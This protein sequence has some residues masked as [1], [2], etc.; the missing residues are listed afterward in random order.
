MNRPFFINKDSLK[1]FRL[2]PDLLLAV[3]LFGWWL[4]NVAQAAF[5]ELA[6]DEAYYWIYAQ[7]LDWGY[8]DHPPMVALLIY[9]TSWIPGEIGVR[10]A[11]TLL[12]PL[13]LYLFWTTI[14]PL[15]PTRHQATIY[16]LICF[17]IPLLQVYGFL[18]LPDAPLVFCTALF[19]WAY[20]RMVLDD[21]AGNALMLGLSMALLVYSKYHGVVVILAVLFA[22]P[23]LWRSW[24]LYLAILF[25]LLLFTPHLL[26]QYQHDWVSFRYHLVG[27]NP[28]GGFRFSYLFGL[29]LNCFLTFNPLWAC[30][31]FRKH[32]PLRH[33]HREL[34]F[35]LTI[36]TAFFLCSTLKG[37]TQAQW[38]LPVAFAAIAILFDVAS[39]NPKAYRYVNR[40][41]VVMLALFVAARL[42]I[43]FN[44]FDLKGELWHNKEANSQIASLADGRPVQFTHSY[45]A[46]AKYAFYTGQPAYTAPLF[47]MR[48][49][50]WQMYD[51]DE[52]WAHQE[53][54]VRVYENSLADTLRLADGSNFEYLRVSDFKPLRRLQVWTDGPIAMQGRDTVFLPLPLKVYNP[55]PF[56]ICST[57]EQPIQISLYTKLSQRSQPEARYTLTDTLRAHDTTC[58]PA[59]FCISFAVPSGQYDAGFS[60]RYSKF[61]GSRNSAPFVL[62]VSR[63]S[64]N[65]LIQ[66]SQQE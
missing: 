55:Y 2:S 24:K 31:Y 56:D 10:L 53:V 41:S 51:C 33:S 49:S 37:P 50:Q 38:M 43:I 19:L 17:S 14:R 6:D 35:L 45:S 58:V 48:E 1:R 20:R 3:L 4:L 8:F 39:R 34:Y 16:F 66:V 42:L 63:D 9:L 36:F 22:Y 29:L 52:Q 44:P 40:A 12:L 65:H 21:T 57:E 54:L 60:V 15:R 11:S 5:T 59:R 28:D 46:S 26:W 18:A 25:S 7:Q 47:Y 23:R 27:R 62:N 64:A 30:F 13:G 61:V 32:T